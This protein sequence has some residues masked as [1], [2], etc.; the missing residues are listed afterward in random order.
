MTMGM[1]TEFLLDCVLMIRS[2]QGTQVILMSAVICS[3][4]NFHV[5]DI[6]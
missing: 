1:V 6:G 2:S 5:L 4:I 3:G